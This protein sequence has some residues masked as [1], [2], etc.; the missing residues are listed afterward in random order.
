VRI[1]PKASC[2]IATQ[3]NVRSYLIQV[4]RRIWIRK[5][6]MVNFSVSCTKGAQLR[7]H[8]RKIGYAHQIAAVK[9]VFATFDAVA[10]QLNPRMSSM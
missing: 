6:A 1:I 8:S 4:L 2:L 10:T 9:N 7:V 3:L 5:I